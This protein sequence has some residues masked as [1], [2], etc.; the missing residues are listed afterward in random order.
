MK[1]MLF[2]PNEDLPIGTIESILQR[3]SYQVNNSD[4][5]LDGGLV[6]FELP[7]VSLTTLPALNSDNS[8]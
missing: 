6:D 4:L 2:D 7:V 3:S 1:I 8:K 5:F